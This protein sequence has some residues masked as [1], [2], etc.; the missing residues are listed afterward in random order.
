MDKQQAQ[1]IIKEVFEE[2][3]NKDRFNGFIKNFLNKMEE[4]PFSYQGNY[5][6]DAYK[7][8]IGRYERI[9]KYNDG[10]KRIDILIVYLNRKT[11]IERARTSQRNFIAGYLDGKYGSDVSK[12]AA[13][14]A[15]VSPNEEDWRFSLVKMDYRF[16]QAKNGKVKVK[17]EFTPARRWSFLVGKN[18]SSHTAQSRL[19]PRLADD[20][21]NPTLTQ[22]EEAFNIEKVTREFFEKY[23]ELFLWI[24]ETLDKIV[25]RDAKIKADLDAKGVDT[26]DFAKKLLGQIVFLYFLQ[27]KGWFGVKRDAEWGTGTKKFLKEL[28][29]GKYGQYGNFFN[30]ILEPLFYEALRM[31]RRHDDNYYSR[32]N[33]KIPF[34]NGGLFDPIGGYDWV[35]TDIL[36]P[37]ELFSNQNKTKE[38]DRGNGILDIFD[39]YNF[40]V[41][42]DEP[43]EKEVAVDPEMLGKVFENLLVVKDRKSKGTYYTPR[44]IVHYMCQQ[45]LINYLD[46]ELNKGVTLYQDIGDIQTNAFGN[47]TKVGQLNLTL[48]HKS[49]PEIPKKDIETLIKYGEQFG[50]NEATVEAR[51][52]ETD[53]YSY[54]L[55]ENIRRN[56]TLIDEKLAGIRV[57]DPAVG[58][59]AFPVGMMHEI[60]KT[61]N[62][63]SAY[64]ND[65]GR[66]VYHFK[67][68]CIEKSLYGVD[69]DPGAVE[70]AKLRLW[71]SLV[72]D[73]E[74]IRQIKPLP[75]LDYRIVC[76]NSL[77]DVEENLFNRKFFTELEELKPLFFNET[78]ARKKQEYKNQIDE[79]INKITNG[80]E[81]F[82][83]EV[84]FSE[85]FHKKGGFDVVIANPPYVSMKKFPKDR[86]SRIYKE[87]L[88]K[89]YKTF[90]S[91]SDL[92]CCFFE[93]SLGS[94]FVKP[95]LRK[96]GIVIFICSSTFFCEPSFQKLRDLMLGREILFLSVPKSN[97]FETALVN[98]AIMSIGNK[99]V[100]DN[101]IELYEIDSH[102]NILK[103]GV[104]EQDILGQI[105]VLLRNN[106]RTFIRILEK[107]GVINFDKKYQKID[108]VLIIN[109]GIATADN[110]LWLYE[111]NKYG[112]EEDWLKRK[113][114]K[115]KRNIKDFY[116]GETI[117]KWF[118]SDP[119]AKINYVPELMKVHKS[120]ARPKT[121]QF[122]KAKKLVSQLVG[123]ELKVALDD[124]GRYFDINVNLIY[125]KSEFYDVKFI[126]CFFN[127]RLLNFILN[128]LRSNISLT[129]TLLY[130]MPV[131]RISMEK[132]KPFITLVNRIL[133]ITKDDDYLQNL[134]KHTQVKALER[135]ID[136]MVYQLY[137][138]TEEEIGI[139]EGEKK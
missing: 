2:S 12:D 47:E 105:G 43:L 6:P 83:F 29:Q 3:F 23:R 84:Y 76:G 11:S 58:S 14:V 125:L 36:L 44:E 118:I 40:T 16:E 126:L 110:S 137:G 117:E 69:I 92:Y 102:R 106:S 53:T 97:V 124:V 52:K 18:E 73:E 20:E 34:L 101:I 100:K 60:V 37:N 35:H 46:T 49:G 33:C 136:Q 72:V 42:E 39:R 77:L 32:F 41:K 90:A 99:E 94:D 79:L 103:T 132:Q 51:G 131:R 86:N 25:E 61:R 135:E 113:E 68:E 81:D 9:G 28:F 5:I 71:L 112:S 128:N 63:L 127:S 98:T 70:I 80:H 109:N 1:T 57:C 107:F 54:K 56:A 74:D 17:E 129:L 111:K 95:I 22:M 78:N 67:R 4:A 48:K 62:V 122:F 13:L 138:L 31:D 114:F 55:S 123:E 130:K 24:K 133:A 89:S 82:D 121:S 19:V 38:G 66:T 104:I 21:H 139:V 116:R 91:K 59:G 30:D 65:P 45:S 85:V 27:K 88:L 7:L 134:Q 108:E 26:I 119:T 64:I 8:F 75:N 15:F 10:E 115:G 50:E 87:Y 93:K 96:G 120:T